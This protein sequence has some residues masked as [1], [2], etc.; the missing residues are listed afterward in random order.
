MIP[1]KIIP[2]LCCLL[3]MWDMASAQ[4]INRKNYL[5][6][7]DADSTNFVEYA[8]EIGFVTN[9]DVKSKSIFAKSKGY[10]FTKPLAE[11]G[12]EAYALILV[13]STLSK[14]NNRVI[15]K[16]AKPITGKKDMWGD[17]SHVYL[18]WEKQD[19]V[20]KQTWYRVFVYKHK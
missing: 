5:D 20:S 19:P 18:E 13:I 16:D 7:M 11:N 4:K 14:Q 10:V 2:F 15:I 6:L 12:N 9:Y 1:K 3:L 17:D 8:Q